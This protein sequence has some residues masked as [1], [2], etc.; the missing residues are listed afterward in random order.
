MIYSDIRLLSVFDEIY[1]TRSVSAAANVLDLGQPAVSLALGKL[2]RHFGDQLFVRTST[3]MEPTPLGEQLVVPVRDALEALHKVFGHLQGFDP[4]TSDRRFRLCMS[5]L[6]QASLIPEVWGSLSERAPNVN[7]DIIPFTSTQAAARLLE[8]GEADIAVGLMPQLESGFFQ[9]ALLRQG[10][11]LLTSADHPRLKEKPSRQQL[12]SEG[13]IEVATMTGTHRSI[14][15][16]FAQEG[17]PRVVKLTIPT[18]L[19]AALIVSQTDLLLVVPQAV[20][21]LLSSRG[22]LKTL[23]LPFRI[24]EYSV[25]QYWHQRYDRDLGNRWLR[26]LI[27]EHHPS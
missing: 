11:V 27:K 19:S 17:I 14:E 26:A 18:F 10:Y 22:V 9:Q 2:R 7:I 23:P 25:K 8:A 1:K 12:K 21:Q 4:R 24:P 15:R 3:G 16:S 20:G 6:A 5:D 13:F